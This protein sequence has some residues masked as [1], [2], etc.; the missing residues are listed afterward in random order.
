MEN[1]N[2]ILAYQKAHSL[3]F[4]ELSNISGGTASFTVQ[5]TLKVTNPAPG[6]VDAEGDQVYD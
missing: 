6:V 1:P 2:R 3:S 4:E 5:G